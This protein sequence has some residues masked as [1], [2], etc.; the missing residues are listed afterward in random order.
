MKTRNQIFVFILLS[1]FFVCCAIQ[2]TTKDKN[3]NAPVV[4]FTITPATGDLNTTFKFD[5]SGSHD[6]ED[7]KNLEAKFC[8]DHGHSSFY[9]VYTW[10]QPIDSIFEHKYDEAGTY[11]IRC[12][13]ED[14]NGNEG[15]AFQTLTVN[16]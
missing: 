11:S 12:V 2:C 13:I 4:E 14:S 9:D 1:V 15:D 7:G 8:F 6:V 16:P 10:A 5:A 3:Q